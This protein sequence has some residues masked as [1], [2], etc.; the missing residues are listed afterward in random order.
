MIK[1]G[2]VKLDDLYTFGKTVHLFRRDENEENFHKYRDQYRSLIKDVPVISGWYLWC[3]VNSEGMKVIYI[4]AS[5]KSLR[6]RL[7]KE[8]K[9]EYVIFWMK[10]S[11]DSVTVN[12]LSDLYEGKYNANIKRARKKFGANKIFWFGVKEVTDGEL[13]VVEMKLINRFEHSLVNEDK[14]NYRKIELKLF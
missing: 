6:E 11:T 3:Q 14:R 8:L 1:K 4:G 5:K 7:E 13:D 12:T 2:F 9:D 10:N